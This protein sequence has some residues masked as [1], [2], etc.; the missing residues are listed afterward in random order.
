MVPTRVPAFAALLL[1]GAC[2]TTSAD[3]MRL[4]SAPRPQTNPESIQLI[5]Q[6]PRRPFTV[7]A[8]V[9]AHSSTGSLARVRERVVKEAA[10]IGGHAVWFDGNSVTRTGKD[11]VSNMVQVSGK[12]IVFTDTTAAN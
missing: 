8:I 9:S 6:E 5:A 2:I 1:V 4:D 7:I 12:V 11:E 3:I 10:H